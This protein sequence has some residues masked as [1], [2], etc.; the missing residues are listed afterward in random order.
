MSEKSNEEERV[1][2]CVCVCVCGRCGGVEVQN[3]D[4]LRDSLSWGLKEGRFATF[5]QGAEACMHFDALLHTSAYVSIRQHTSAYVS[6]RQ[7]TSAYVII[8]SRVKREPFRCADFSFESRSSSDF[9]DFSFGADVVARML[10]RPS[11]TDLFRFKSL[12]FVKINVIEV[13]LSCFLVVK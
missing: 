9:S 6:I 13:V 11:P 4:Q 12:S 3:L 2:V 5:N 1:C 8:R 7:H 10:E